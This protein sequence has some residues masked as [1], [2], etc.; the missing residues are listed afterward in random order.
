MK[1]YSLVHVV[2]GVIVENIVTNNP[3]KI[4][5]YINDYLKGYVID[6]TDSILIQAI[7]DYEMIAMNDDEDIKFTI[8]EF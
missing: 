4:V 8:T 1:I 3:I 7:I 2:N 6:A 5:N